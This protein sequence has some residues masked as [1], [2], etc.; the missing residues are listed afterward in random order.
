MLAS[1]GP[2]AVPHV[3]QQPEAAWLEAFRVWAV[4]PPA[5]SREVSTLMPTQVSL[6]A[7]PHVSLEEPECFA[8]LEHGTQVDFLA[9]VALVEAGLAV[10]LAALPVDS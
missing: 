1:L 5:V 6:V 3:S 8:F 4:M 7:F 9:F 10:P 2:L